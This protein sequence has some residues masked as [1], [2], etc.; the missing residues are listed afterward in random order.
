MYNV[1]LIGHGYWGEKLARNFHNS[2]MFNL[3]SIVD[4]K[5]RNLYLAKKNYPFVKCFNNY[6]KAIQNFNLDLVIIASPTS[7]HFKIAEYALKNS[8]HVLVEK[9]LSLSSNE[10]KKLNILAKKKNKMIF[11]DYPFLFSGTINFIKKIVEKRTYGKILEIESFREQAPVRKDTNVIWD[12]G[13]HDI[14][15]LVYLLKSQPYSIKT[16]HKKNIKK[17]VSD[18]V[19]INLKYKNNL[20]VLI[21]NSWISPTKI[22]LLKIKFQKAILYCDENESLYKIKIYKK[23]SKKDWTLYNLE[24]PEIDLTEPLSK[25]TSYVSKSI[26][27]NN[28]Y[29]FENNFNE[30]VTSLLE[31]INRNNA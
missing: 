4:K 7:T 27:E 29:L 13:T 1:C 26:K 23:S 14:S 8:N 2:E 5:Q 19:Y 21:K 30:K 16:I 3:I 9:P 10:V 17:N 22:R 24:I 20:N 6:K 25:M 11:V 15:I 18:S 12:L 31:K 28:N